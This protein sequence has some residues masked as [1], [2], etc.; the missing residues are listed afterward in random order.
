MDRKTLR[1]LFIT[2]LVLLALSIFL[3]PLYNYI[4]DFSSRKVEYMFIG[5]TTTLFLTGIVMLSVALYYDR[6][7]ETSTKNP[8]ANR[9]RNNNNN[10]I[11]SMLS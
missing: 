5:A 10:I 3:I 8:L 1:A 6:K 7:M 4:D 11:E 9:N 2:S